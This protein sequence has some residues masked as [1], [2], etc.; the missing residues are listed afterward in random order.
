MKAMILAAGRGERMRPLTDTCPKPL[1]RV[2]S[3]PLIGWHLRRLK[4]AGITEIVINHAWL[5]GQIEA[6]L[7]NGARYG[8][9]IAYSPE[10]SGGLETAGGI[11]TAL[12]LLGEQPFLVINGDVLTDIDFQTA[13]TAADGLSEQGLLAHLWLVDNPPHHPEGDFGL[14]PDGLAAADNKQGE[15]LT[16]SGMGVYHPSLLKHT[17]AHQAAKLAPLLRAAMDNRQVRA[18]K[19]HGLWLDVGTVERLEEANRLAASW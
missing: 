17:P 16:F 8:V 3:E 19:H 7:G 9:H 4:N 15:A 13:F 1:L 5:G 2:G 18:E 12:P 10:R 11:A 6:E 14:L